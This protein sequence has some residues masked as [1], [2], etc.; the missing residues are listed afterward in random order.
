MHFSPFEVILCR[1]FEPKTLLYITNMYI[2]SDICKVILDKTVGEVYISYHPY[3]RW[4]NEHVGMV[5]EHFLC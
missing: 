5:G 1:G 4:K 3:T 2:V